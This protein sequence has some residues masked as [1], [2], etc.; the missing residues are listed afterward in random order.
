MKGKIMIPIN[1][2]AHVGTFWVAAGHG[3]ITDFFAASGHFFGHIPHYVGHVW[4]NASRYTYSDNNGIV[5][6]TNDVC[7]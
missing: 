5:R 2:L 1:W 4:C 7:K 6:S 3:P